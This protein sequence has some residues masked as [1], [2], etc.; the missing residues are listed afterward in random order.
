MRYYQL[1]APLRSALSQLCRLRAGARDRARLHARADPPPRL[2]RRTPRSP[3]WPWALRIITLGRFAI[4]ATARRSSSPARCR[5][6]PLALLKAL[7]AFGGRD[8]AAAPADR[9]AV[10]RRRSRRR[11]RRL[12]RRVAPPAQAAAARCTRRC[13]CMTAAS[14]STRRSAGPTRRAFERLVARHSGAGRRRIRRVAFAGTCP[15]VLL[16]PLSD[17]EADAGLEPLDPRAPAQRSSRRSC[18]ASK[19]W[20][21][22]GATRKRSAAT[23][24]PG[25]RRPRR[26][27]LSRRDGAAPCV[28]A[29]GRR[30]AG[31]P[32][33]E[34]DAVDPVAASRRRRAA[35]RCT[36]C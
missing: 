23:A 20:P 24:G 11:A 3:S 4:E 25:D 13:S 34:A 9:R 27:V 6:K 32:A 17:E 12:Q 28:A 21:A 26:G 35:R 30:A 16:R 5:G 8:V 15:G 19:R 33:P 10:A 29:T 22:S 7:I 2:D 18:G 31:L 36:G 14:A 1:L